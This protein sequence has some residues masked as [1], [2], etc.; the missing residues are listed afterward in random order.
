MFNSGR[1]VELTTGLKI[2]PGACIRCSLCNVAISLNTHL[3]FAE[4][5]VT[6]AARILASGHGVWT[7]VVV[8]SLVR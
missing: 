5:L 3:Y 7:L 4:V 2:R 6:L 1:A 8:A